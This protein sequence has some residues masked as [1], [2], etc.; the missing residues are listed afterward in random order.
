MADDSP[1]W[2]DRARAGWSY[3]GS[4][5]PHF[6]VEPARGQ[7]SVWDYPRPPA[8]VQDHRHVMVG[9]PLDPLAV[10]SN[11]L[12]VLE[13]ASPPTFY[14]PSGDV[15][16]G[17]LVIADGASFCEWKGRATFWA[18]RE[19]PESAVGW[20]YSDPLPGFEAIAGHLS[21]YPG[22]IRC[23]VDGEAVR[24]QAGGFYGGWITDDIVGPFKGD[25]GTS[26]W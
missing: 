7:E 14:L 2:L 19:Q 12:R 22:R 18:L 6:A 4:E 17:R 9:D 20:S 21:F 24:P 1:Q 26:G 5:R 10:T 15:M 16:A 25:P 8:I 3:R 13:T 23:S 11:S